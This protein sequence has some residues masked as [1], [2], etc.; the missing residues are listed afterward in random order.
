MSSFHVSCYCFVFFP[1]QKNEKVET[2]I[3]YL[4][5]HFD[6]EIEENQVQTQTNHKVPKVYWK[7]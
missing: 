7:R 1:W 5:Q 2:E 6:D 3:E 4:L